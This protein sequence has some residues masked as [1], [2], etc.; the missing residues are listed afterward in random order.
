MICSAE[1][2]TPAYR[3]QFLKRENGCTLTKLETWP[4]GLPAL[5][6]RFTIA[7]TARKSLT[8]AIIV[9]GKIDSG[10]EA[11]NVPGS[12]KVTIELMEKRNQ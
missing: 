7:T 4:A 12:V 6:L 8:P 5:T 2:N 9:I 3:E 1:K 11:L 10:E